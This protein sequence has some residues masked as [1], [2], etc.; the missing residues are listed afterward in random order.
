MAFASLFVDKNESTKTLFREFK[1]TF[2]SS[3]RGHRRAHQYKLVRDQARLNYAKIE[4][5]LSLGQN[6]TELVIWSVLPH[7]DSVSN[8]QKGAWL[9]V[10]ADLN[11]S[12]DK[13]FEK[14]WH[15]N[16]KDYPALANA[17]I[18]F[19]RHCVAEPARYPVFA[20]EFLAEKISQGFCASLLSPI[21]SSLRP[22][23]FHLANKYTARLAAKLTGS[24]EEM[25]LFSYSKLN[26]AIG[27]AIDEILP[28]E[29]LIEGLNR[30]DLFDL[31]A[32][33]LYA[34][35]KEDTLLP[36][37][38]V[39]ENTVTDDEPPVISVGPSIVKEVPEAPIENSS[40]YV[41]LAELSGFL[42]SYFH[43]FERILQRKGQLILAGSPGTG[44]SF[45]AN[46]FIKA[47]AA[48]YAGS[49]A[50]FSVNGSSSFED[51]VESLCL[52]LMSSAKSA[53]SFFLIDGC[54]GET[55]G[56]LLGPLAKAIFN[57]DEAVELSGGREITV[58]SSVGL[59]I[60]MSSAADSLGRLKSSLASK[61]ATVP[62]TFRPSVIRF[63]H[64]GNKS[65]EPLIA[66][67]ENINSGL[68]SWRSSIGHGPFLV[69]GLQE[70]LEDI[71]TFEIEPYL[72]NLLS[73]DELK[74]LRWAAVKNLLAQ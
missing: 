21:L 9:H 6:V 68:P 28:K 61:F 18:R 46:G 3:P 70:H 25:D 19:V 62:L 51:L 63:F 20:D 2:L 22:D 31:F 15:I 5:A 50:T 30:G 41:K 59:I 34:V 39:K 44:K 11:S 26:R 38:S 72:E 12:E 14:T 23:A 66:L 37:P 67:I 13:L 58:P 7:R 24:S 42:P 17:L 45:L 55:L 47:A 40:D 29:K 49:Y 57:R 56:Q 65:F 16:K 36:G 71:W 53:R 8:R 35:K 43:R 32:Y 27:K 60:T 64:Q 54:D 74:D 33:W 4:N 10:R 1:E 69:E 73:D 48:K 52:F